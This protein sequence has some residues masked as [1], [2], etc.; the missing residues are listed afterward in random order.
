M[1]KGNSK[2]DAF[3]GYIEAQGRETVL[4]PEVP[5]TYKQYMLASKKL[6]H[7]LK[8]KYGVP[9]SEAILS[10]IRKFT[11]LDSTHIDAFE[12]VTEGFDGM[13]SDAPDEKLLFV[14][15]P[16]Y[17]KLRDERAKE[18]KNVYEALLRLKKDL[19]IHK[20][21]LILEQEEKEIISD[22]ELFEN[23]DLLKK[24][25]TVLSRI[26]DKQ[27]SS[28]EIDEKTKNTV[29]TV[30]FQMV[31]R[32]DMM[33][34]RL[35][36]GIRHI[37]YLLGI[38]KEESVLKDINQIKDII[39]K[40]VSKLAE[41]GD[42]KEG[43]RGVSTRTA[44][45]KGT[46]WD[47]FKTP[48]PNDEDI[49]RKTLLLVGLRDRNIEIRDLWRHNIIITNYLKEKYLLVLLWGRNGIRKS[50]NKVSAD[51]IRDIP[52]ND[53]DEGKR[54]IDERKAQFLKEILDSGYVTEDELHTIIIGDFQSE[55]K[56]IR[57]GKIFSQDINEGI[58]NAEKLLDHISKLELAK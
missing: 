53:G 52:D 35:D 28:D 51:F 55:V 23:E 56:K 34:N 14:K 16:P 26:E 58:L 6:I 19:E 3:W 47:R 4:A 9:H 12:K 40:S 18:A 20:A 7:W 25:D 32:N 21:W 29:G 8:D 46:I 37:K 45:R 44:N 10:L 24:S 5:T 15:V 1:T 43:L 54:I 11:G 2:D 50:I 57:G 17:G 49:S 31:K 36:S 39:E 33:K 27:N 30:I 42:E 41:I 22:E 38:L 13:F 48:Q